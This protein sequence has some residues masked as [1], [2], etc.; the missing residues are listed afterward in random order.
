[1]AAPYGGLPAPADAREVFTRSNSRVTL[2]SPLWPV[3][4][5]LAALLLPLDI[6]I[7]RLALSPADLRSGWSILSAFLARLIRQPEHSPNP[8]TA[9]APLLARKQ[10][11]SL[12]RA[13]P[14]PS[15]DLALTP[16]DPKP[17]PPPHLA[18]SEVEESVPPAQAD[19]PESEATQTASRLLAYKRSRQ[20]GG[21]RQK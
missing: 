6:A 7:R 10:R 8:G 9:I 3:L 19:A 13:Q 21:D 20:G 17:S 14:D 1:L 16:L 5:S 2:T 18:Q 12:G 15:A 11:S 4:L